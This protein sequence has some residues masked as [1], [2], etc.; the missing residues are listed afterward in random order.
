MPQSRPLTKK[1]LEN[2]KVVRSYGVADLEKYVVKIKQNIKVF[3]EAIKKEKA[4][5]TRVTDMMKV[6]KND[7]KSAEKLKKLARD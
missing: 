6:L 5:M 4:E 1:E 3:E 7:I 2:I